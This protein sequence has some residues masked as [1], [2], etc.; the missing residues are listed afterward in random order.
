MIGDGPLKSEIE[1][2]C[3]D[4]S[5]NVIFTGNTDKV[6]DLLQAMDGMIL[7][8]IFEGLP[9]VT[10][11]WQ[12]NGLPCLLSDTISKECALT[13][14]VHFIGLSE[15][16]DIWAKTIIKYVE[17][18]DRIKASDEGIKEVKKSG[19]DLVENAKELRMMY[20]A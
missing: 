6:P 10:I 3:R 17:M 2:L 5:E 20:M 13:T 4:I 12:I 18:N 1:L 15:S 16:S 11:E 9:L 8:S 7:P 14:N 19:F